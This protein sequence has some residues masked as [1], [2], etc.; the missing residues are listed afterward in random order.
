MTFD[1]HH[2]RVHDISLT[3]SIFIILSYLIIFIRR[4]HDFI[5]QF[6][7]DYYNCKDFT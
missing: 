5:Y 4:L 7:L 2:L 3:Y 1:F 6:D